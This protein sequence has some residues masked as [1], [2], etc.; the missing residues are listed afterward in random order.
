[1]DERDRLV[2][3]DLGIGDAARD[4]LELLGGVLPLL[5]GLL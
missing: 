1:V 3:L 5:L 2:R 4:P